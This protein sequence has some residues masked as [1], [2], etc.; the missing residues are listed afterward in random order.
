MKRRN[1]FREQL[2]RRRQEAA[3][4]GETTAETGSKP[5]AGMTDGELEDAARAARRDLLDAQHLE[6]RRLAK[7]AAGVHEP[8][9][10]RQPET[11]ALAELL[12]T[13][14]KRP[15]WRH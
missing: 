4:S 3:E 12:R 6:V 7:E 14:D 2:E 13:K 15:H 10:G 8:P 11:S 9:P 5:T 1:D